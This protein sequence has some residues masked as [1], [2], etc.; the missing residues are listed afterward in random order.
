MELYRFLLPQIEFFDKDV[1]TEKTKYAQLNAKMIFETFEKGTM[2]ILNPFSEISKELHPEERIC[3]HL[4]Y[5]R[6]AAVP[7]WTFSKCPAE[8]KGVTVSG[9][10]S[11]HPTQNNRQTNI[12]SE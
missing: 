4:L 11:G 6:S 3:S 7:V 9:K 5:L 10:R 12:K 1:I 8:R 2:F